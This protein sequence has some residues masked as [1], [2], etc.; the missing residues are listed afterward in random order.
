VPLHKEIILVDDCSTDGTSAILDG[1][2]APSLRQLRHEANR[3]KGAAIQTGLG[4]ATGDVIVIQD[5]D[6]EYDPQDLPRLLAPIVAGQTQVVYG[7]RGFEG[8]RWYMHLGNRFVTLMTNVLYGVGLRDMETCYKMMTRRVAEGLHLESHRFDVEAELTAKI[9]RQGYTIHEVP[10]RYQA[11]HDQK[12]LTPLD[13]LPTLRALI[14]YRFWQP[15]Q[16]P[17]EQPQV[18]NRL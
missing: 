6:L 2:D 13:G 9:L 14:R 7:A 4:A 12:K 17:G 3:G 16:S 15:P 5:A 18:V 8:Q 10:I 11:R 1:L